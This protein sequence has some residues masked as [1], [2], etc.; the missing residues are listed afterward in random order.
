M[1]PHA[2]AT[3]VVENISSEEKTQIMNIIEALDTCHLN[4]L[5]VIDDLPETMWDV[6]G[7]CGSWSVKDLMAHLTS[8]ELLLI[9]VL[10]TAQGQAPT[11][12][13]SRFLAQ[14][15]TFNAEVVKQHAYDTAQQVQDAF[16]DAQITST[17]LLARIPADLLLKPGVVPA[18]GVERRIADFITI[19]CQHTDE[20][21]A[22]ISAFRNSA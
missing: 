17:S 2:G 5:Q 20:H 18:L 21:R 6:P 8:Y 10:T 13:L 7:V 16:H 19:I 14:Q 22:Q 3:L 11:P 4:M 12:L 1:Q 15:D 9:D